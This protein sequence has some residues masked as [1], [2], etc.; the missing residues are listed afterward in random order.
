MSKISKTMQA[1]LLKAAGENEQ[2]LTFDVDG[3][4]VDIVVKRRIPY[5]Q[6]NEAVQVMT[7][8]ITSDENGTYVG[9]Q[10]DRHE[11]VEWY[12]WLTYFT[13]LDTTTKAGDADAAAKD[14]E[15]IWALRTIPVLYHAFA[16]TDWS[17]DN[18]HVYVAAYE[19]V[20]ET[21]DKRPGY[22]FLEMLDEACQNIKSQFENMPEGTLDTLLQSLT[23]ALPGNN[24]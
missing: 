24:E 5:A 22:V 11:L 9:D 15:R 2:H 21:R 7:A 4:T 20:A 3:E 12:I 8:M 19:K 23:E 18:R 17:D 1:K 13:N 10:V 14:L 16:D 6:F